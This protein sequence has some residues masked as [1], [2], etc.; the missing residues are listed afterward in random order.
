MSFITVCIFSGKMN[1]ACGQCD[2]DGTSCVTVSAIM[3]D[4]APSGEKLQVRLFA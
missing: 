4:I 2:G 1:D 3:P